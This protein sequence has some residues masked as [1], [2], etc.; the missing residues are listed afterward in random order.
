M[1]T[2]TSHFLILN[3]RAAQNYHFGAAVDLVLAVYFD[4]CDCE[5]RTS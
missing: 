2:I 1:N 5:R 3:V 4:I